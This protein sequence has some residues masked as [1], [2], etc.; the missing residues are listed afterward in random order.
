MTVQQLV[1][2][3]NLETDE[4]LDSDEENIQY[5]NYAI[6]LLSHFL[7]TMADSEV[8]EMADVKEEEPVPEH[9]IS[10]I[11]LN[12][13]P[14]YQMAGKWHLLNP[15]DYEIKNVRYTCAKPPVAALDDNIPFNDIYANVLVLISS[16]AIKKKIMMPAESCQQD[17]AFVEEVMTAIKAAKGGV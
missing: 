9:F 17:K 16:Y 3:I 14:L 15:D 8:M 6:D 7:A 10:L 12:G 2:R 1:N 11:P 5:I 13:Y 4:L